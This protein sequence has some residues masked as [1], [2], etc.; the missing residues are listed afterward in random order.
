MAA[1]GIELLRGRGWI[2][3][4]YSKAP[5]PLGAVWTA[6]CPVAGLGILHLFHPGLGNSEKEHEF[7]NC[8]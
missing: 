5:H 4:G 6:H 1:V 8:V 2:D 3:S 7:V